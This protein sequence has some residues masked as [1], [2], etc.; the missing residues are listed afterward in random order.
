[1]WCVPKFLVTTSSR[2]EVLCVVLLCL[3][4]SDHG[5]VCVRGVKAGQ[6]DV[7]IMWR[8]LASVTRVEGH[9]SY[10]LKRLQM[11]FDVGVH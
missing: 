3:K 8:E 1:M 2:G 6:R 5:V 7:W 9:Q 10:V 11:L 4:S